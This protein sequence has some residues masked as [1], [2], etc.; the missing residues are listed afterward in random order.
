MIIDFIKTIVPASELL[1]YKFLTALLATVALIIAIYLILK[2][3]SLHLLLK[4]QK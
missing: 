1:F 4:G 3:E 2:T